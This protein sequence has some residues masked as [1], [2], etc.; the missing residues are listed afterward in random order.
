MSEANKILTEQIKTPM[1]TNVHLTANVVNQQK[2]G[3]KDT[4][5][6]DYE[7]KLDPTG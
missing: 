3:G 6:N 2:Q 1:A 5:R 7:S 4:T